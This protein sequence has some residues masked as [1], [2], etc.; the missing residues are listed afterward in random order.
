MEMD[1]SGAFPV[2]VLLRCSL[3]AIVMDGDL[4]V[5]SGSRG[6]VNEMFHALW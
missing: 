3:L 1:D 2:V 4:V 6:M 5:T